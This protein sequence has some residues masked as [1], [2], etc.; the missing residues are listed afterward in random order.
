[1]ERRPVE[2]QV[3]LKGPC[4]VL[5]LMLSRFTFTFSP[6]GNAIVRRTAVR[7]VVR[8]VRVVTLRRT[9]FVR[10]RFTAG[11][12]GLRRRLVVLVAILSLPD[13]RLHASYQHRAI[14][15]AAIA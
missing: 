6:P 2:L 8:R 3:P 14:V 15:S 10:A 1:M 12:A 4:R 11:R 13:A 7:R 9:V 5:R